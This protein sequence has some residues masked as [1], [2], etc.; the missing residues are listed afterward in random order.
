MEGCKLPPHHENP[1]DHLILRLIEPTLRPLV[2]R[3]I[4]P[5][6]V[7]YASAFAAA[8]SVWACFHRDPHLASIA[9]VAG[10]ALDC[11]DGFMARRFHMESEY[12]DTIDHLTDVLAFIGLMA[13]VGLRAFSLHPRGNW[14]LAVEL[15]LLATSYYHMQCQEK[16]TKHIAIKGIGGCRCFDKEHLRYTRWVGTGTL[17]LWHVFLIYYYTR[18][19]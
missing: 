13:F 12:G 5:N 16:D 18:A 17:M 11:M 3:G 8:V 2:D 6:M 10:Y 1:V 15:V 14:P 9:W 4:T 7:T 19:R